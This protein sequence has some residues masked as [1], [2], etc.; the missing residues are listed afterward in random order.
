[1]LHD[2]GNGSSGASAA[3]GIVGTLNPTS[4]ADGNLKKRK[5]ESQLDS[6]APKKVR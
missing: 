4:S 3:G 5:A 2:N 6:S 1:L